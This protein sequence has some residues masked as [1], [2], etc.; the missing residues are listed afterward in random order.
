MHVLLLYIFSYTFVNFIFTPSQVVLLDN[1]Y[2]W[3]CNLKFSSGQI[4]PSHTLRVPWVLVSLKFICN[5]TYLDSKVQM[6]SPPWFLHLITLGHSLVTFLIYC[7]LWLVLFLSSAPVQPPY[8]ITLYHLHLNILVLLTIQSI[9]YLQYDQILLN[10]NWPLLNKRTIPHSFIFYVHFY[11][12]I[13]I[14]IYVK[15]LKQIVY[16]SEED[17]ILSPPWERGRFYNTH[18]YPHPSPNYK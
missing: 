4:H 18:I 3:R 12:C 16:H 8:I 9:W 15:T 6:V 17:R 7:Y 5:F 13:K 2:L 10:L 11:F 1:A 14:H